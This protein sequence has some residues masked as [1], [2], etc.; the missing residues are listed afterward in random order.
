MQVPNQSQAETTTKPVHLVSESQPVLS[1]ILS[2]AEGEVAS[3][4]K[5]RGEGLTPSSR[6]RNWLFLFAPRVVP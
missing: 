6:G 2:E 4:A 3:R 5:L 1:Y